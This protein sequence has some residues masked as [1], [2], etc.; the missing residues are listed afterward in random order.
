MIFAVTVLE[1]SQRPVMTEIKV[2]V[3][4]VL[5][6]VCLSFQ[7]GFVQGEMQLKMTYVPLNVETESSFLM[8]LV[9]MGILSPQMAALQLVP[10]SMAGLA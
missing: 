1:K 7:H 5:L 2:T 9:M 10:F 4:D 3:K 6:I 8:R